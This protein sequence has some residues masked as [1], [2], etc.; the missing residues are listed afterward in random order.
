MSNYITGTYAL[1][2]Y[3]ECCNYRKQ[4][5]RVEIWQKGSVDSSY[6]RKI[7][8]IT[9]LSLAFNGNEDI[10]APIVKTIIN[11]TM[12]DTWDEAQASVAYST[13]HGAW[14]E[15]YTPDSTAYL[16]KLFTA[17]EG[18]VNWT[19]RW[20]G[21]ITPDNWK[22]TIGYRGGVGITARDN[23]GHLQDF[24][25]DLQGDAN[26][27]VSVYDIIDGAF[28]KI[29]F[30]MDVVIG[31]DDISG[32]RVL[33]YDVNHP[34]GSKGIYDALL[35]VSN[36]KDDDWG[37]VLEDVLD[38]LGLTI[39]FVDHNTVVVTEIRNLPL[40]G[41][42]Y[43]QNPQTVEFYGQGTRMLVP[44]YK[45]VKVTTDY[46]YDRE[47]ELS[48]KVRGAYGASESFHW[49]Y[50]D[51]RSQRTVTGDALRSPASGA[52][53]GWYS[54]GKPFVNPASYFITQRGGGA[55]VVDPETTALLIANAT[56]EAVKND[57]A[58]Y[59]V[60]RINTP[61]AI[62]SLNVTAS[63][64]LS[65]RYLLRSGS[66]TSYEWAAMYSSEGV[67]YWWNGSQWKSTQ[68]WIETTENKMDFSAPMNLRDIP[69]G[70][71][72]T[73][74]I[75]NVVATT[76]FCI[77][78]SGVVLSCNEPATSLNADVVTVVNNETYN[79]RAERTPKYG[80]L[81]KAVVWNVP[82]N[83]P[84]VFWH[85]DANG[86]LEPF[87]YETVW[88]DGTEN[89][90]LPIQWAK[91][92]LMFHHS[93]LQMIEG[94]VGVVDKGMWWFDRPLYYK[95]HKF[96][97]RGGTLDLLTGHVFGV[98]LRE[99]VDYA[100]LWQGAASVAPVIVAFSQQ[101]G[102][103]SLLVTCADDKEWYVTGL[104]SWLTADVEGGMGSGTVTL[105]AE[106]NDG[107]ARTRTIYV[108]GVAIYISQAQ[109]NFNLSAF[110]ESIEKNADGGSE[111]ITIEASTD[112]AWKVVVS[113]PDWM[114]VNGLDEWEDVGY[115]DAVLI[116]VQENETGA[117]RTGEIYLYDDEDNLIQT[118]PVTQSGEGGSGED[119]TL[120]I[121]ANVDNPTIGL[122][123]DG[124]VTTYA[125]GMP[126]ASGATVTVTIA[127]P[128]Y[129][130]V[131]DTFTMS[132]ATTSRYYALESSAEATITP[133]GA[134]LAQAGGNVSYNIS[135]PQNHGWVLDF[136]GPDAYS[137]ITGAGVTSGS[138]SVDGA[139]IRGTGNAVVYLTVPANNNAHT[140]TIEDS[141]FYFKDSTTQTRTSLYI[142]QL[143][144]QDSSVAVTGVSLNKNSLSLAIG[145]SETLSATVSPSN[146]TNK[147]VIWSSSNTSIAQVGQDGT[148]YARTAGSCTITATSTDGSNKSGT[149]AVTVTGAA[150]PVTGVSLN[151]SS[152]T[153]GVGSTAQL[154]PTVVPSNASNKAVTWR[155]TG[156][157]VATVDSNGLVTGVARGACRI[158]VT[159]VDGGYEAYC[160]INV[161]ASGTMEAD[162]ATI[163]S[164]ATTASTPL[165]TTNM[166]AATLQA[167]CAAAW[168]TGISVDRSVTPFRVRLQ[169]LANSSSSSRSATVTVTGTDIGGDT[170][171]TTFTLTQNGKSS[172]ETPCTGLTMNGVADI[173]NSDNL[174]DY[175]VN[176]N[177]PSTT[178]NK[179][180]WT[181]T[182]RSGN[183]TPYAEIESSSDDRCSVRVLS[184]A[185]NAQ[186][187]VKATNYYNSSIYVTKDITATYVAPSSGGYIGVNESYIE[188]AAGATQDDW[189]QLTL[190]DMQTS[191]SYLQVAVSGFITAAQVLSSGKVNIVFPVNNT[192]SARSGS[193]TLTGRNNDNQTVQAII[194]YLQQAQ[195]QST[196]GFD[197]Q[198]LEVTGTT[199]ARFA[200]M[201]FNQTSGNAVV[202][203]L[204]YSLVGYNSQNTVTLRT[205][206]ALNDRTIA[207]L[208]SEEEIYSIS[209]EPSGPTTRYELTITSN[210]MT[211]TYQ[212]DGTDPID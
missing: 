150:V 124:V 23:L 48:A 132:T 101:G 45:N 29:A 118:I 156:T 112:T 182:D 43:E 49:L 60:G 125:A 178:Q 4:R 207:A 68:T 130:T 37:S 99:Y 162:D 195:G 202:R 93:T 186:L 140:R 115:D 206:G 6:P 84:N 57:P 33:L 14:E 136:D 190:V 208:A 90:G 127:K 133:V 163:K 104:P 204:M 200:V 38:S 79:V 144:T 91:Q 126:V 192:G 171:T 18:D 10:D 196:Y 199:Q 67:D 169:I 165:R 7:G 102:I 185:N 157:G 95:G 11:L 55:A 191:L 85:Y 160:S 1:K 203:N 183:V 41:H 12:A 82:G 198:A 42:Y 138:A 139:V 122:N 137:K 158:Y 77:G 71:F 128:G 88:S 148:V 56:D 189:A 66:L 92:T 143:G 114:M 47:I 175:S 36:F 25:F 78:V 15:F 152:L 34:A 94:T 39:R 103:A 70:G 72:L 44:A 26:G 111:Y 149:C 13:K 210:V 74:F 119:L 22:E 107:G 40:C 184:G 131:S 154:I 170:K 141:P 194:T 62:I 63:F 134:S 108:A 69:E 168:V 211:D 61:A 86:L 147:N 173:Q 205:S 20:S 21:Y 81:S 180:V 19:H 76:G 59:T 65:G 50:F 51:Q 172:S 35:L 164:Q 146:A 113:D 75:R 5:S 174:A 98:S 155:S 177:P 159:T 27:L 120:T 197:I 73:I 53:T 187:R 116:F 28:A 145:E 2:Y 129:T 54:A 142:N 161:T 3:G 17:E 176:F 83:Y 64:V 123:I 89:L 52:G 97:Q 151:K 96:L 188:V 193:V 58:I 117:D 209:I 30:P 135:D 100:T 121:S 32:D 179:V 31:C 166:Q 46:D 201:F 167:S 87:P 109:R 110:P 105:T 106:V 153:L 181:V 16:V 80:S 9:A 212:G 8:D 24:E